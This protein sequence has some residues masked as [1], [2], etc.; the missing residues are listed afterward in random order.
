MA[1]YSELEAL[2]SQ[3]E[4]GNTDACINLAMMHRGEYAHICFAE[5][6]RLLHA[7]M[8]K[9]FAMQLSQGFKPLLNKVPAIATTV[10]QYKDEPGM[11]NLQG[12]LDILIGTGKKCGDDVLTNLSMV[13]NRSFQTVANEFDRII[14]KVMPEYSSER[15]VLDAVRL[16][17]D[18]PTFRTFVETI[19]ALNNHFKGY[20]D[21]DR[22]HALLIH[23]V[24]K[25]NKRAVKL[26]EDYYH[27][28][29]IELNIGRQ[30]NDSLLGQ[31]YLFSTIWDKARDYLSYPF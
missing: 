20:C 15:F 22:C 28:P 1:T 7:V 31:T 10:N 17:K 16:F 30:T 26:L 27:E 12:V 3:A 6:V 2:R 13:I 14:G 9:A 5:T 21:S 25:E 23:A 29:T 8:F 19:K 11:R 24:N 18:Q 4:A